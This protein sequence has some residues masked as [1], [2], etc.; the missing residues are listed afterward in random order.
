MFDAETGELAV[1]ESRH[2]AASR[3]TVALAV[4][5]FVTIITAASES[6]VVTR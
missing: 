3:S 6:W 1:A 4:D 2:L 5:T